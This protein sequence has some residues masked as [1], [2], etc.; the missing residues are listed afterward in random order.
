MKVKQIK[1]SI[2]ETEQLRN[3]LIATPYGSLVQSYLILN[4]IEWTDGEFVKRFK[5]AELPFLD[6]HDFMK[7]T[8][9]EICLPMHEIIG[10]PLAVCE[11]ENNTIFCPFVF[12]TA[13]NEVVLLP[14]FK[15][16]RMLHSQ[17]VAQAN[18]TWKI[19]DWRDIDA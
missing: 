12:D 11:N 3:D 7:K 16:H 17:E 13:E 19:V 18:G 14:L 4:G 2:D 9:E 6:D 8:L 5:K 1:K 15:D 10:K